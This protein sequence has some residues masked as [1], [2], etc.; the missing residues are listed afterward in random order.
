MSIT[1]FQRTVRSTRPPSR[2]VGVI[3][4][5][6][7]RV[8]PVRRILETLHLVPMID[9][10]EAPE[11]PDAGTMVIDCPNS[12]TVYRDEFGHFL[13]GVVL[14]EKSGIPIAGGVEVECGRQLARDGRCQRCG[15]T[16]WTL[17]S[18]SEASP[19]GLLS[20]ADRVEMS[21]QRKIMQLVGGLD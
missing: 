6:A 18:T 3:G 14:D 20:V 8:P 21:K 4:T 7:R 12:I 2:R 16:N 1:A 19:L 5:L 17:P 10:P 13:P 9:P 11:D 15:S